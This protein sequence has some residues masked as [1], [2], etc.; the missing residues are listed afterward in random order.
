MNKRIIAIALVLFFAVSACSALQTR[1]EKGT[2]A[3]VVLGGAAGA[4]L[5]QAIGRSTEATLLGMA[6]GAIVGGIT[7][8]EIAYYMD[9]QE[10]ELQQA[11]A[12]QTAASLYRE[13]NILAVT[14]KSDVLF[15]FDSSILKPAAYSE[16]DRVANVLMK[17]PETRIVVEGHTDSTGSEAYNQELSKRRAQAVKNVIVS[18]GVA[19]S[20]IEAIGFGESKPYASNNTAGGRQLNRRVNVIIIPLE[21]G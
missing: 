12:G 1:R 17:Y 9:Q 10:M 4:G 19:S 16:I 2:A 6:I 21:R 7:G 14:F 5:G 3:G 8:H 13:Q 15:D 20:R 11:L 18:K